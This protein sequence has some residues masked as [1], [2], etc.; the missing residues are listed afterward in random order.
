MVPRD[1]IT[2]M[3]LCVLR[4]N[5]FV[6]FY[7][8]PPQGR[9]VVPGVWCICLFMWEKKLFYVLFILSGNDDDDDDDS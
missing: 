3:H 8:K 9:T 7:Q 6:S 4:C 5:L 2:S 1:P